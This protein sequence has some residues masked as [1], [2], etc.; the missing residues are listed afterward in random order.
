MP[1]ITLADKLSCIRR[2]LRLRHDTY[3]RLIQRGVMTPDFAA[4][5]MRV[6]EAIRD[7]YEAQVVAAEAQLALLPIAGGRL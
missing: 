6:M 3:P 4:Y 1:D 5:Q 2:E 7:D